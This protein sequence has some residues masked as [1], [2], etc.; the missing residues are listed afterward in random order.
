[1]TRGAILRPITML[2]LVVAA[3]LVLFAWDHATAQ[4][5][6][7]EEGTNMAL[8]ASGEGVSCSGDSCT[9][10]LGGAFTLIV[11]VVEPPASGYIVVQT[12]VDYGLYLYDAENN[13]DNFGPGNC[14]NAV[15]DGNDGLIDR[16]DSECLDLQIT[17][18][19][20]G[21]AGAELVWPDIG[22]PETALRTQLFG[23]TVNH[24]GLTALIPPLPVSR[25]TGP[26]VQLAFTCTDSAS[27]TDVKLLPLGDEL[28]LG[29]GSGFVQPDGVTQ[30]PAKADPLTIECARVAATPQPTP[31]VGGLAPTGTGGFLDDPDLGPTGTAGGDQAGIAGDNDG[32]GNAALWAII[33]VL[34]AGAAAGL[35]FFGWRYA[36]GRQVS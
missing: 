21:S 9:V 36:R 2:A 24:S 6:A 30:V 32:G 14:G 25:F 34:A 31:T 11:E 22:A 28:A 19:A 16:V 20:A 17:Y 26:I 7:A 18:Q 10:P 33:G 3:A 35:G 15:D 5:S 12:F 8:T 29:N 13:E 4:P 27:E 1:M 23:G